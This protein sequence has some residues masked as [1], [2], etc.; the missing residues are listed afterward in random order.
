MSRGAAAAFSLFVLAAPIRAQDS[1]TLARIQRQLA[2]PS[3]FC[4]TF[5]QSKTLVGVRQPVKSSG[6]FCVSAGKGVLWRT[7]RP[8]PSSLLVTREG[9]TESRAGEAPQKLSAEQEPGVRAINDL[10]FSL[11]AGDLSRLASSFDVSAT[12]DGANWKASLSPRAA[13]M[14]ATI[15]GIDLQGGAFVRRIA[16]RDA[17]G[18]VTVIVF[19]GI[20]T[21]AGA[22]QP[23]EARELE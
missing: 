13:G 22:M 7:L 4:G 1:A 19:S 8:F 2:T 21:G 6:R 18:D 10:L 11:F 23:E 5:E 3:I 16:L 17:G 9:I 12:I 20:A 14:R 15:A